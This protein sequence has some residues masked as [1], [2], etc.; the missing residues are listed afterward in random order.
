MQRGHVLIILLRVGKPIGPFQFM[1]LF[2][3]AGESGNLLIQ[4]RG[5]IYIYTEKYTKIISESMI[6]EESKGFQ[7]L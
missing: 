2:A 5:I 7:Y 4:F 6:L 3:E 1:G